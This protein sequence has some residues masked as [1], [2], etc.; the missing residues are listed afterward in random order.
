MIENA[1]LEP[2]KSLSSE[3]I[4]IHRDSINL[5]RLLSKSEQLANKILTEIQQVKLK[6]TAN[7][8]S[9]SQSTIKPGKPPIESGFDIHENT[10]RLKAVCFINFFL[11]FCLSFNSLF[12]D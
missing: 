6:D 9:I 2:E 11:F 12:Q 10:I 7:E 5:F 8:S 1:H 4:S 3:E